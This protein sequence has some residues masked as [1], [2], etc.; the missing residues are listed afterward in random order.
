VLTHPNIVISDDFPICKYYIAHYTGLLATAR[1][2]SDNIFIWKL[3]GHHMPEYFLQYG[4][5]VSDKIED[6]ID[7]IDGKT[8]VNENQTGK[9]LSIRELKSF[10]PIG[11]IA[12]NIIKYSL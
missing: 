4:A 5:V 1:Q 11:T 8:F 10:D 9:S 12:T 6:L 2:C 7:F 3:K